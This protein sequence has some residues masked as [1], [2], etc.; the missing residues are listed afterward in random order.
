MPRQFVALVLAADRRIPDPVA[1]AA[2]VACKAL[3]PV[4]G[5][6][7]ILRVLKALRASTRIGAIIICGPDRAAIRTCAELESCIETGEISWVEHRGSPTRSTE[8]AFAR[9]AAGAPILL[10]TADHA[11]LRSE[12]V[13][14]FL[15]QAEESGADAAIGL[16]DATQLQNAFPG[17]RRTVFKLRGGGVRNCNLFALMTP[18]GRELVALW[19]QVEQQRKRPWRLI[20]GLLGIDTVLP[21]LLRRLTLAALLERVSS[22]LQI[23]IQPV[24]LPY[25]EAGIDVDTPADLALARARADSASPMSVSPPI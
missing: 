3:A 7:M 18:R 23:R 16:I 19:R 5:R 12:I 4:G 21:Y 15:E 11:L 6:A 17:V 25:P 20:A 24:M 13:D 8:A 10:T 22:R 14:Y 9:V 1:L 2:G